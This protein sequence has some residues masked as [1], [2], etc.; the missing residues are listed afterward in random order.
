M[1]LFFGD[2]GRHDDDDDDAMS[3]IRGAAGGSRWWWGVTRGPSLRVGSATSRVTASSSLSLLPVMLS[4]LISTSFLCNH[5]QK[6]N[7]TRLLGM[8]KTSTYA[9]FAWTFCWLPNEKVKQ[10]SH[11]EG[12]LIAYK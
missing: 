3:Q 5:H 8:C 12:H 7:I 10:Q 1:R 6:H 4:P 11:S 2:D 9:V